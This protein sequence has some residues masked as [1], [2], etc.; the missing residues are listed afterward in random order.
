MK[1]YFSVDIEGV[2]GLTHWDEATQSHA[3]YPQFQRQMTAEVVAAC[4]GALAAGADEIWIKDAH[5]TG[6]NILAGELPPEARLIRGWSGSPMSMVQELDDS[7]DA[8]G[9][10]G[11][12]SAAASGGNPLAHTM[13]SS[14]IA[15]MRLNGDR[16]SEFMLH[17]YAARLHGVP[18]VFLSGDEWIC[19]HARTLVPAIET[20]AVKTG[21]G[22]SV[23]SLQPDLALS[24]IREGVKHALS[25]HLQDCLFPA[26][27][28]YRIEIR[29]TTATRA[30]RASF[31]PGAIPVDDVT[32]GFE[33]TDYFEI[34]RFVHFVL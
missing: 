16:M 9:F 29:F 22:D 8:I 13:S 15:E 24:R 6:R 30:Y 11:Y 18:T 32:L 7:F 17:G 4:Q 25:G 19:A 27:D 34:L 3:D 2:T 21:V 31:Y 10:I 23:I 14:K 1:V 33:H 20:V 12:H 5:A 26:R 28:R